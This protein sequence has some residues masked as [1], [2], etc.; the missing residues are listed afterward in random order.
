MC[1]RV[2]G[3]YSRPRTEIIVLD[4]R[5]LGHVLPRS[6][7]CLPFRAPFTRAGQGWRKRCGDQTM[8]WHGDMQL[9]SVLVS[10]GAFRLRGWGPR[11]KDCFRLEMHRYKAQNRHE[12]RE[13]CMTCI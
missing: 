8:T 13:C 10:V 2:L 12:W 4:L 9:A 11:D 6:A 1:C 7:H 3:A 5:W